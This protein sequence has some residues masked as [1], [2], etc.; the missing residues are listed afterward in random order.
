[1][2]RHVREAGPLGSRE[3]R[4]PASFQTPPPTTTTTKPSGYKNPPLRHDYSPPPAQS[5]PG[6]WGQRRGGPAPAP[7]RRRLPWLGAGFGPWGGRRPRGRKRG[8][9]GGGGGGEGAV[10][11]WV[12]MRPGGG[13]AIGPPRDDR[14][15]WGACCG[16]HLCAL[17]A[18]PAGGAHGLRL[19]QRVRKGGGQPV[20][21]PP[22]P[23]NQPRVFDASAAGLLTT[24]QLPHACGFH[25]WDGMLPLQG[26]R[27]PAG[28]FIS[29][30]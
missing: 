8:E 10:D 30:M 27:V 3:G 7:P 28:F 18:S 29:C 14:E 9:S 4:P 13:G 26:Q 25:A 5:P 15:G 6:C 16:G 17:P 24:T 21:A 22:P 20:P 11:T 2:P 12:V 1:M 23:C 19:H